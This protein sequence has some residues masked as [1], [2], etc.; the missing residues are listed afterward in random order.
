MTMIY[1]LMVLLV[2]MLVTTIITLYGFKVLHDNSNSCILNT[3]WTSDTFNLQRGVRQ[4]CLLSPYLFILAAEIMSNSL[5]DN[6][7]TRGINMGDIIHKIVNM[8]MTLY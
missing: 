4:G 2:T 7:K 8:Q 3:G 1:S 6:K 5:R